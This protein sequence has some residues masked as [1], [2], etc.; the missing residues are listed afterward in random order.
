MR[1]IRCR[2]GR[3]RAAIFSA[4]AEHRRLRLWLNDRP[5]SRDE[6]L[7][8]ST[9]VFYFGPDDLA[10]PWSPALVIDVGPV[11]RAHRA[12]CSAPPRH[13]PVDQLLSPDPAAAEQTPPER[14]LRLPVL[15]RRLTRSRAGLSTPS[16]THERGVLH[17]HHH[18]AAA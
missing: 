4:V 13:D 11:Y 12:T 15:P 8:D 5:L 16:A 10:Y 1:I 17:G 6:A 3:C 18:A 7:H 2:H 9:D 14:Q